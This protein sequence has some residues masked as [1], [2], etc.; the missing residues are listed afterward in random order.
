MFF[1]V[2]DDPGEVGVVARPD[3]H[4]GYEAGE[5]VGH[6]LIHEGQR[7]HGIWKTDYE[8]R[9]V[10]DIEVEGVNIDHVAKLDRKPREDT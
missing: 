6:G 3:G 1:G 10:F 9:R 8:E 4:L 2:V 5:L 7:R